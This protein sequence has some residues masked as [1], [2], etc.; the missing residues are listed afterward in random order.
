MRTCSLSSTPSFSLLLHALL[1][2]SLLCVNAFRQYHHLP[3]QRRLAVVSFGYRNQDG[4]GGGSLGYNYGDEK[5]QQ[6]VKARGLNVPLL[7]PIPGSKPLLIG[8]E[9]LLD[10]PSPAQ[11]AA[12]EE[13]VVVHRKYLKDQNETSTTAIDAAPLIAVIDEVT[14]TA[15]DKE[16][17]YATLAAVIGISKPRAESSPDE[18][19]FLQSMGN[20]GSENYVQPEISR[21]RMVGVGRAL[22]SD[23]FY[24]MPTEEEEEDDDDDYDDDEAAEVVP[25][26]E[27]GERDMPIVMA[28]FRMLEDTLKTER[29]LDNVGEKRYKGSPEVAPV[30]AIN[31]MHTIA[32]RVARLHDDRRRLVAGLAAAKSRLENAHN[33]FEDSDGIGDAVGKRYTGEFGAAEDRA[34]DDLLSRFPEEQAMVYVEGVD[35]LNS[36]DNFG[37]CPYSS[38][39]SIRELTRAAMDL[40][41]PYYSPERRSTE[42]YELEVMSFVAYRAL[43]GFCTAADQSWAL[44]CSNSMERLEKA[45][46]FMLQH[47]VQLEQL[48]QQATNDLRE[49]GEE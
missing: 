16:G 26:V 47:V 5:T 17:R 3:T 29:Q 13:S 18:T 25:D 11:W 27:D 36:L 7:G 49:C 43:D 8:G 23:V 45:C 19:P 22:L 39:S 21:V 4:E 6:K 2:C 1:T 32:N 9:L 28:E 37:V 40:F 48:A 10:P 12:L 31:Q 38:L 30:F 44:R 20:L 41:E 24:K 46:D 15:A 33:M 42:E 35:R 14:A 34:I